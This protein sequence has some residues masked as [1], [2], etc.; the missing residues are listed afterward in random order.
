MDAGEALHEDGAHAQVER[1]EHGGLARG[2]L[3]VDVPADEDAGAGRLRP[4]HELGIRVL[5]RELGD[6]RASGRGGMSPAVLATS[7]AG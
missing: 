5:E 6:G 7:E 3:A 1:P 4:R 2:A